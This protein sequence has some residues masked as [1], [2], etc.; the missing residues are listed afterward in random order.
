MPPKNLHE[1][2]PESHGLPALFFLLGIPA[3]IV[4]AWS[5]FSIFVFNGLSSPLFVCIIF[6]LVVA[7]CY[8]DLRATPVAAGLFVCFA[9]SSS[10]S[11]AGTGEFWPSLAIN[12]HW[13]VFPV[14]VVFF[15]QLA[16][17]YQETVALLKI[18]AAVSIVYV[19]AKIF[20]EAENYWHWRY[21]PV[22][23]HIRHLGLSIG[24]MV[25]IL[26]C[27]SPG[28]AWTKYFFRAV[29]LIGLCLVFWTG[30]RS[31]FFA[32]AICVA[33]MAYGDKSLLKPLL[34][35]SAIAAIGALLLPPAMPNFGF[36]DGFM[37]SS[38]ARSVDE[39]SS[40][41]LS[42]WHSTLTY[43]NNND[44]LWRGAGGNGFIRIQTLFGADITPPGHIHPH[45]FVV[46]ALCDW[47]II[48]TFFFLAFA[49]CT[50]H[51]L[52]VQAI[53][54][55]NPAATAAAVY[56]VIT[57]MLDATLYHLEHLLYF[58]C[59]LALCLSSAEI[60]KERG[61]LVPRYL[62]IG[63]LL[64]LLIPHLLS[65]GY[66]IGMIWYFPTS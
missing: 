1:F 40:L 15:S 38:R 64:M 6:Y 57:G 26:Y 35:D 25:V 47:G 20:M 9:I 22:F 21:P 18:A 51:K 11:G 43:I 55:G 60:A 61:L 53:V 8:F 10:S 30:S 63:G 58:A 49:I 31:A 29:R 44:L 27:K 52:P 36:L 24:F 48:G 46:Q 13:L 2:E 14:A 12:T 42:L 28:N 5:S 34:V 45:N 54:R 56:I 65:I 19:V 17:S 37:R 23:G 39:L 7:A 4:F 62:V 59:A 66:R 50:I 32:W 16:R 33:I 3:L 41:R